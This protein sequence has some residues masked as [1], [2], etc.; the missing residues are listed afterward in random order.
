MRY[1]LVIVDI[2]SSVAELL[3]WWVNLGLA[4]PLG[5]WSVV[6]SNPTADMSRI[7]FFMQGRNFHGFPYL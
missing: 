7:G 2:Q 3:K 1:S 6:G 4:P 5:D